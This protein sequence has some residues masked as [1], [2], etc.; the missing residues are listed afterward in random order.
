MKKKIMIVDD[1]YGNRYLV[2]EIFDDYEVYSAADGEKMRELLKTVTPD[3]ILMDV[4]LPDQD[5]FEL[6]KELKRHTAT[7][8]IPVIFLT[9][10]NT[11]TYVIRGIKAGGSDFIVK[12]FN[13]QELKSRVEKVLEVNR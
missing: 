5:G 3:V 1:L 4:N 7:K 11:S 2:E 10:H 8:D 12:P 9:V 13:E 6:T